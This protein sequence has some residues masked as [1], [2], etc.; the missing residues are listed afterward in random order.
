LVVGLAFAAAHGVHALS[1]RTERDLR[2]LDADGGC[3]EPPASSRRDSP[4][5]RVVAA[6]L[7]EYAAAS[8]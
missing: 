4:V 7:E 8:P 3:P 5:V 1:F 6:G 2:Y